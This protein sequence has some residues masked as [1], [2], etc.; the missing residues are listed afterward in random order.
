MTAQ[1]SKHEATRAKIVE[2]AENLFR[3]IGYSKTT[4]ADIAKR[5]GMSPANVYRFFANKSAINDAICE[6][7]LSEIEAQARAVA[8]RNKSAANRIH[9][10]FS[11]MH[12]IACVQFLGNSRVHEMV[13][14]AIEERWEAI[15]A[16]LERL[17]LITAEIVAEGV[18]NGEFPEQ[19]VQ[20]AARVVQTAMTA[21]THPQVVAQCLD[22]QGG[23]DD[24]RVRVHVMAEYM[25]A[26]LK[27]PPH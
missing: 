9:D 24:P 27:H 16:H 15:K 26:A 19:D 12:G 3:T 7:I 1:T 14:V 25:V 20:Q 13:T 11:E 10:L 17:R 2:V 23:E 21:F 6:L 18:E 4:V 22:L 8:R 5:C